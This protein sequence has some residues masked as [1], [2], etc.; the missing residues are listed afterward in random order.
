MSSL[1]NKIDFVA[2]VSVTRANSNGDDGK[3]TAKGTGAPYPTCDDGG[4]G[5][6]P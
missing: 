1:Q 5:T 4:G 2:L 3:E 6:I